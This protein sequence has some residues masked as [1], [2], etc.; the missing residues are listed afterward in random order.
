MLCGFEEIIYSKHSKVQIISIL[1][2][3]L[4]AGLI[5]FDTVTANFTEKVQVPRIFDN[6]FLKTFLQTVYK[7][8]Y[9]R[10]CVP[11]TEP[12]WRRPGLAT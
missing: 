7:V 9:K 5:S 1:Q 12:A 6:Y 11:A 10:N 2:Q 4:V 3:G 8:V